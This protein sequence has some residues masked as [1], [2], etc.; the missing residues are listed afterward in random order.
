MATSDF[1]RKGS[2][3]DNIVGGPV[4]ILAAK[5]STSSYP[6]LI[7]EVINLATYDAVSPWQDLGLSTE[8]F[9]FSDGFE[10]TDWISQ[11][12]GK[13]N[14]QVGT[15]NRTIGVTLMEGK[16]NF[17]MDVVHEA[18][19]RTANT[20]GDEVVYFWDKSDVEEWRVVG[21]NL[22]E[23]VAAGSNIIMDVFPRAKRS[24]AD[25]ETAW[26]RNNPQTHTVEFTPFPDDGVPLNANWYRI[27]QL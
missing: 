21:I 10:T 9:A 19:G 22:Q 4:R 27:T 18:D 15:W 8:P 25:S 16:L 17:L 5:R 20:D 7:S 23:K 26:D 12:L 2:T 14:V 13:I 1:W 24:G 11:Q 6:E 3:E